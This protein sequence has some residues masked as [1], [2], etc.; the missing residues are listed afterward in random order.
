MAARSEAEAG[1]PGL[2]RGAGRRRRNA[3]PL[4]RLQVVGEAS[5]TAGGGERDRATRQANARAGARSADR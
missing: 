3:E 2:M 4:Q 1:G 5:G